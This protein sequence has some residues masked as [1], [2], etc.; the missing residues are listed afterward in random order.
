MNNVRPMK[1]P[2]KLREIRESLAAMT[3]WHAGRRFSE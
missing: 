1:D 3:D 2:D